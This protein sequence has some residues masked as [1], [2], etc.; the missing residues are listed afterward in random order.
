M[1]RRFI[2]VMTVPAY[3]RSVLP[4]QRVRFDGDNTVGSNDIRHDL[5]KFDPQAFVTSTDTMYALSMEG[6]GS[7]TALTTALADTIFKAS[8]AQRWTSAGARRGRAR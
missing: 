7:A 6:A 3:A 4:P 8:V 5:P 1:A 2:N